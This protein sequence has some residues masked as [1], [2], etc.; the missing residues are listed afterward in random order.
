MWRAIV[1]GTGEENSL[2]QPPRTRSSARKSS[3]SL[4]WTW[5]GRFP[6]RYWL[7]MT[8]RSW[9]M[10]C[11]GRERCVD[12]HLASASGSSARSTS[13]FSTGPVS[14]AFIS[15]EKAARSRPTRTA[16]SHASSRSPTSSSKSNAVATV[17]AISRHRKIAWPHSCRA[18]ESLLYEFWV[19]KTRSN[20]SACPKRLIG[21]GLHLGTRCG[22]S[23]ATAKAQNE[24]IMESGHSERSTVES[25]HVTMVLAHRV[26]GG[27]PV[28]A[29]QSLW[30]SSRVNEGSPERRP[31]TL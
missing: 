28:Y 2:S 27:L 20:P 23:E 29:P 9:P 7:Y 1:G 18:S 12:I 14:F 30:S 13:S 11:T 5:T 21:I 17:C 26:S 10:S 31:E 19:R 3:S 15:H 25:G 6:A 4:R 8:R 24:A 22:G 16:A